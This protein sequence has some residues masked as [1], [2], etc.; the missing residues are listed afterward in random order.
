M[1]RPATLTPELLNTFVTLVRFKGDASAAGRELDINQPSMSKRLAYFQHVGKL[2]RKPWLDRHG[3]TWVMT[4]E[5][6]R[7]LPVVE[8]L[9]KRYEHMLDFV[10][11]AA[12]PGL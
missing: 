11:G 9:L 1:P 7:V 3:K 10:E 4:E 8:D 5:G 12:P 2:I 6:Q